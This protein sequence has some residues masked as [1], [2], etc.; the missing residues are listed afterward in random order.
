MKKILIILT[1]G[2]AV[3]GCMHKKLES[4]G[5][6]GVGAPP[7]SAADYSETLRSEQDFLS[8]IGSQQGGEPTVKF[9]YFKNT[10]KVFFQNTEKFP[11][12]LF[13][14]RKTFP[15]YSQLDASGFENLIFSEP[16][17]LLAGGIYWLKNFQAA[18]VPTPGVIG[19]NMY[20]KSL[21]GQPAV[22][23]EAIKLVYD[24]LVQSVAFSADPVENAAHIGYVFESQQLFFRNRNRLAALGIKSFPVSAIVGESTTSVVY[25]GATSYG[26]LRSITVDEFAAGEYSSKD[27]LVLD[28]FETLPLDLG[29]VSGVIT[30]IPQVPHSHV[31]FRSINM[32]TPDV[33]IPNSENGQIFTKNIG[34]LVEFKATVGV[35]PASWSI[36]GKDEIPDIESLAEAYFLAR[37]PN[38]PEPRADLSVR[39]FYQVGDSVPSTALLD[40]YGAKGTNIVLLDAALRSRGFDRHFADGTFLMPY[41]FCATHMDQKLKLKTCEK[42]TEKCKETYPADKCDIA[43]Q[44]CSTIANQSKSLKAFAESVTTAEMT[45][46]ILADG[47]LRKSVLFVLRRAISKTAMDAGDLGTLRAKIAATWPNAATRIRF[48]TSSNAEDLAGLTGAGLYDSKSACLSDE[49]NNNDNAASNCATPTELARIKANIQRLTDTHDPAYAG[50]I[51]DLTDKLTDKDLLDDG[52]RKVIASLWNERAF[53]SRDYYRIPHNKIYMGIAVH[54]SYADE[55][56]NGV[57]IIEPT[58]HGIK[59]DIVNQISDI[60]IT[61]PAVPG[62]VP[63]EVVVELDRTSG[64]V[65]ITRPYI[66]RSNQTVNGADVLTVPQL[67]NLI[68]QLDVVF[69]NFQE[70][71]GD[72]VKRLDV[73]IKRGPDGDMQIKQARAL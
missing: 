36:R 56:A 6:S 25:A 4:S 68:K 65:T 29:P 32:R 37:V 16:P 24:K 10:G 41:S 64:I 45:P 28:K 12:H 54:P 62:A 57:V 31:I 21:N 46:R 22:N 26:Y 42:A 13:F 11:F 18:D 55:T 30:R 40:K 47:V 2:F 8:L 39:E 71:F 35:G 14:L 9:T 7:N 43:G 58:A 23:P 48:R 49:G 59:I 70:K 44:L 38:L 67:E 51:R 17:T 5:T 73:E 1:L 50:L 3:V 69:T 53:L 20:F 27:I 52:F 66:S 72:S 19:F 15:E 61:N 34:K 60:S 63:E 33:F